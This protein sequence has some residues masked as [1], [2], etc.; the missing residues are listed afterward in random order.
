MVSFG[1]DYAGM[2]GRQNIKFELLR[3]LVKA[4]EYYA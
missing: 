4:K 1:K 2:H 3:I